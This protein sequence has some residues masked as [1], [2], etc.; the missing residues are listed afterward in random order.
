MSYEFDWAYTFKTFP[1]LMEGMLVTLQ[2][3]AISIALALLLGVIGG[4]V[5]HFRI[6]G[7]ALLVRGYVDFIRNTPLL[8]QIFF[9]FYGLPGIGLKLDPFWSGVVAL[10]AWGSAYNIEIIRGGMSSIDKGLH[11]AANAI[12]LPQRAFIFK[13]AVPIAVRLTL[14]A[15]MNIAVS[16]LKNS[17]FLQ[18]IGLAELTFVAVDRISLDFRTLELFAAIGVIYLVVITVLSF[19]VARVEHV[20]QR[21]FAR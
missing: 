20:L 5:A 11:E 12:A 3:S 13:I 18:A 8:V 7:L 10:T 15:L 16:V 17:A 4:S 19:A 6:A 14:P 21:P 9:V 1:L 2:V